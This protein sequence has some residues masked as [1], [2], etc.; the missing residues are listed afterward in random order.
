[1]CIVLLEEKS[2]MIRTN[3]MIGLS[4]IARRFKRLDKGIV[5]PYILN[6]LNHNVSGKELILDAIMH[7]N[8]YLDWNIPIE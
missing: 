1:M 6:E 3:A 2:E 5:L 4:H 8:I 7:I